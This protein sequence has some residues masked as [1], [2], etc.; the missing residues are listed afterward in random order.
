MNQLTH[1]N[2]ET[3]K[4]I[5]ILAKSNYGNI[6]YYPACSNSE[7]FL[8]LTHK[9]TFNMSDLKTIESLGYIVLV[10]GQIK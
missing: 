8:S 5:K 9:K 2:T 3:T 1:E 6:Q 7:K 10:S 4:S